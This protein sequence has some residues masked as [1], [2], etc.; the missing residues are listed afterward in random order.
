MKIKVTII[1]SSLCVLSF[2]L[3]IYEITSGNSIKR[4]CGFSG[5]SF[6]KAYKKNISKFIMFSGHEPKVGLEFLH[7]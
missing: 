1:G 4:A 5:T 6:I 2:H 3:N 7:F